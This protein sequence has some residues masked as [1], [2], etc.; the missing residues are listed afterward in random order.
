MSSL[1]SVRCLPA[2]PP[3]ATAVAL[4]VLSCQR[5]APPKIATVSPPGAPEPPTTTQN[6]VPTVT[7]ACAPEPDKPGPS[8]Q[9]PLGLLRQPAVS[10]IDDKDLRTAVYAVGDFPANAPGLRPGPDD[11]RQL[12]DVYCVACHS[13]AYITMQP[14]LSRAQWEAEVAKM[15]SAFGAVVPDVAA[16]RIA[17]FLH[18]YYGRK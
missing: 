6:P 9:P 18:A 8:S 4:S 16:Q 10:R 14:P 1:F 12:I 2:W 7:V 15:R 13:T 11:D 5:P 17:T 3:L